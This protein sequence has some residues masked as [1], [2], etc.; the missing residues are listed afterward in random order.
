MK[1][2]ISEKRRNGAI[3][4]LRQYPSFEEILIRLHG[5]RQKMFVKKMSYDI[6]G[7]VTKWGTK[8][9]EKTYAKLT[10][11]LFGIGQLCEMEKEMEEVV[12]RLDE[13]A[14]SPDYI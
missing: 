9:G 7:N 2:L 14:E 8:V 12:E 6:D 11:I 1:D 13:I 10:E 4:K 3:S 5:K